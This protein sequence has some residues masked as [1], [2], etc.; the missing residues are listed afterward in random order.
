MMNFVFEYIEKS[1]VVSDYFKNPLNPIELPILHSI[2]AIYIAIQLLIV[3]E[4]CDIAYHEESI[5]FLMF[6]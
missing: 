6:R 1:Y 2:N 3:K 5:Y 4:H